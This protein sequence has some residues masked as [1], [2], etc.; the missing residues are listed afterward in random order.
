MKTVIIFIIIFLIVGFAQLTE[1]EKNAQ[2]FEIEKVKLG[3]TLKSFLAIYPSAREY[4]SLN[5]EVGAKYYS[6]PN[7]RSGFVFFNRWEDASF[8]FC[9]NKLYSMSFTYYDGKASGIKNA[10]WAFADLLARRMGEPKHDP[11]LSHLLWVFDNIKIR[12]DLE[13]YSNKDMILVIQDDAIMDKIDEGKKKTKIVKEQ[14]SKGKKLTN[15]K[16]GVP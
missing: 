14:R 3:C 1:Y 5:A 10:S 7:L 11:S 6:V 9:E 16:R 4:K 8:E 15:K 13:I 2:S 12:F